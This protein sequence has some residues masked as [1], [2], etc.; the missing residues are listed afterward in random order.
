[1]FVICIAHLAAMLCR[2][3]GAEDLYKIRRGP[4]LFLDFE[5][6]NLCSN[7]KFVNTS[8][9]QKSQ[10]YIGELHEDDSRRPENIH[11]EKIFL[12]LH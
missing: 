1:M 11:F 7:L 9:R 12:I 4:S 8:P 2:N 5:L 10:R 3:R 6:K